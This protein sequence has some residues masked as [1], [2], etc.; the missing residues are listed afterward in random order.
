MPLEY[1][2]TFSVMKEAACDFVST[3]CGY[4][5]DYGEHHIL[6]RSQYFF[7]FISEYQLDSISIII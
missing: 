4:M 1:E 5:I 6:A 7:S 3:E 2:S